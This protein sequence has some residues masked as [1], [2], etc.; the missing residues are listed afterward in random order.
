[1][2]LVSN[3]ND[4]FKEAFGDRNLTEFALEIGV[5]KQSISAY[6][7]GIRKPKP[8]VSA[9]IAR[10]LNVSPAWLLGYDVPKEIVKPDVDSNQIQRSSEFVEL[11][12][13]LTS[14]QQKLIIQQI[15]GILN[16]E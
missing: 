5:S 12:N 6:L 1:M 13:K 11:F 4:R 7:K 14:E 8:I 15:K 16:P 3:F 9:E 2:R 10:K